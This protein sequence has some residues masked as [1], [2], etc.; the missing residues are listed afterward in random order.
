MSARDTIK[1][2]LTRYYRS[3]TDPLGTAVKVLDGYDADR[4]TYL[5]GERAASRTGRLRDFAAVWTTSD[6]TDVPATE[7]RCVLCNG[8]LQGVGPHT[9]LD[10]VT[11]AGQHNCQSEG[12]EHRG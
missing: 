10:L 5:L 12:G 3:N 9:L 1:I 4:R 6:G 7:L 11:L 8:L 2:A